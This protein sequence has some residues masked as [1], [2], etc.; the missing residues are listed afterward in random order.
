VRAL[1]DLVLPVHC[2]GCGE[3][4][5]VACARCLT[6]LAGPAQPAWPRPSPPGLP[7]PFAV[8]AYA[9][10][11]RALLLAYKEDGVVALR[12][13]LGAA[14]AESV[15]A[16]LSG[17]SA[18]PVV[19]VPVPSSSAARRRRGC[20][21]V[22]DLARVAGAR[23]RAADAQ[24][25]VVRAL[26]LRRVVADSAGLTATQRAANLADAFA[27]PAGCA[28]LVAGR[29]VVVVDDLLTTGVTLAECA[30][31]LRAAGADVAAAAAVAATA[32]RPPVA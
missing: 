1:L 7:P 22:A 13:P 18:A 12:R 27:V 5:V 21:V 3:R 2:A 31:A 16:A 32:R 17:R 20:D 23:A 26:R 28:R 9:G 11:V 19:V 15:R 25:Q 6:D 4:G 29:Q 10:P 24:V 14:L 30:R 8:T